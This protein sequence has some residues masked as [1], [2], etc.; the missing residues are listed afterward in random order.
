MAQRNL[1]GLRGCHSS[2]D[3]VIDV[4]TDTSNSTE[5]LLY[6]CRRFTAALEQDQV[7]EQAY[8]ELQIRL[9]DDSE[10]SQ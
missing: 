1:K 8:L 5:F 7:D 6:W 2:A 4:M 9:M 3:K 10:V